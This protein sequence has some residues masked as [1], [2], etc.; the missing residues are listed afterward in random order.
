MLYAMNLLIMKGT[1]EH[2]VWY[3]KIELM[4]LAKLD[5]K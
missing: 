1:D 5:K 3:Y 4:A 2:E